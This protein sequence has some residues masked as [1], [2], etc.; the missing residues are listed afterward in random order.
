MYVYNKIN[1]KSKKLF[2][3]HN[4]LEPN[5]TKMC[6]C[7]VEISYKSYNFYKT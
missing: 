6:F 1:F 3:Y 4:V 2:S 5:K 7:H